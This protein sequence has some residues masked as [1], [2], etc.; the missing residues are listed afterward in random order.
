MSKTQK[1][2]FGDEPPDES[3]KPV[4]EPKWEPPPFTI[5]VEKP[6]RDM[7][8][9]IGLDVNDPNWEDRTVFNEDNLKVTMGMPS[10]SVN[11]VITDGPWNTNRMW[12]AK[13]GTA[14][15][16]QSFEDIWVWEKEAEQSR[17]LDD[18]KHDDP[19]GYAAIIAAK[20]LHGKNM[21]AF[22]ANQY[23]R[24]REY[25]RVLVP[26]GVLLLHCDP[27]AS[28]YLRM[29][30]DAVFGSSSY[31]GEIVLKRHVSKN[32]EQPRF[33]SNHDTI[34]HY[35]KEGAEPVFNPD[36]VRKPKLPD[37]SY[38]LEPGSGRYWKLDHVDAPGE[39]KGKDATSGQ[40]ATFDGKTF[41]PPA[42]RH[43]VVPGGMLKGETISQG[44]ERLRKLGKMA[45][46]KTGK[47]R[48]VRY[49]ETRYV[50]KRRDDVVDD[51]TPPG[52]KERTGWATQKPVDFT[53]MLVLA[54]TNPGDI[55][56]D[57]N[58]GCATTLVSAERYG[59][60]WV[61]CDYDPRSI[62][63]VIDRLYETQFTEEERKKNASGQQSLQ[64]EIDTPDSKITEGDLSQSRPH[65]QQLLFNTYNVNVSMVAPVRTDDDCEGFGV[66]D[67]PVPYRERGTA[68]AWELISESEM[69]R[70]LAKF[71]EWK[72]GD[73]HLKDTEMPTMAERDEKWPAR[74]QCPCCGKVDS[75]LRPNAW[76]LDHNIPKSQVPDHRLPN[77]VLL[78][79]PDNVSKS[80]TDTLVSKTRKNIRD[81]KPNGIGNE[82]VLR[83]KWSEG[84]MSALLKRV[85]AG[86]ADYISHN[87]DEVNVWVHEGGKF[88]DADAAPGQTALDL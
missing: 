33:Y 23:R 4:E 50:M 6:E 73:A 61:G 45:L 17:W 86:T 60:R 24:I 18:V 2:L 16:G 19:R 75:P 38:K 78:C 7:S 44:W 14:A 12:P 66:G 30:L 22:I 84:K 46:S 54:F 69:K 36:P 67:M 41:D 58:C 77:R 72:P 3:R 74:I 47:P 51:V 32:F 37:S 56:Y 13:T 76:H 40:P 9:F 31:Y 53:S 88:I 79:A 83:S 42:G 8:R 87:Q 20:E 48:H 21:G 64:H 43:W 1:V 29:T 68:Q 10:N 15:E 85:Q 52:K 55:V 70:Q 27:T 26:G 80:D 35:V 57:P 11:A 62:N 82:D 59:R 49:L 5:R 81:S 28:P 39:V 71:Q 25:H 65:K 34:L 63:V